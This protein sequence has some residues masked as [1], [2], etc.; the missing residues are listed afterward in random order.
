MLEVFLIGPQ[1]R[2]YSSFQEK[3]P[4]YAWNDV[5]NQDEPQAVADFAA[6]D[7]RN[8]VSHRALLS[9]ARART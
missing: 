4:R 7:A 6:D 5:V 8:G 2:H 3:L 9:V 1:M